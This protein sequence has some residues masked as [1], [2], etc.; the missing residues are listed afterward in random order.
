[1]VEQSQQ[2]SVFMPSCRSAGL[3]PYASASATYVP[4]G[5]FPSVDAAVS[6]MNATGAALG[7]PAST[8]SLEVTTVTSD[9]GSALVLWEGVS[10]V[11]D[12]GPVNVLTMP[13]DTAC[14]L[15]SC[16][17]NGVVN[18]ALLSDPPLPQS[19]GL[20]GETLG[21]VDAQHALLVGAGVGSGPTSFVIDLGTGCIQA[22]SPPLLRARNDASVTSFGA[23]AL[24][25][26]GWFGGN[27]QATAETAEVFQ[28]DPNGGAGG[29]TGVPVLLQSARQMH[30]AVELAT[31]ETVLIGGIPPG[32]TTA[33]TALESIS[34]ADIAMNKSSSRP[35]GT[36]LTV[37]RLEPTVFG[38]PTGSIFVGGGFDTTGLALNSVEWLPG[39]LSSLQQDDPDELDMLCTSPSVSMKDVPPWSFAPLEGGAVLAVYPGAAPKGCAS[40]VLIV[41]SGSA[42]Q[43][44][45]SLRPP[46]SPPMLLFAGAQSEPLLVTVDGVTRWQP[47]FDS[48]ETPS[49]PIALPLSLPSLTYLSADP[50]LALW[51]AGDSQIHALRFDT[52]NAYSTDLPNQAPL[53]TD[54]T[55]EFAP[56][57]LAGGPDV[58]FEEGNGLTLMNGASV[59]YTDATFADVFVTFTA[60]SSQLTPVFRDNDTGVMFPVPL[61]TCIGSS[62][63]LSQPV[64]V[65]RSGASI[66]AG[67]VTVQGLAPQPCP[68]H[69]PVLGERVAIGFM[70]PAMG[71]V[72]LSGVTVTRLGSAN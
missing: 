44:A 21:W 35:L 28:S 1:M 46:P 25:A 66:S 38:V 16:A 4:S 61:A 48:F 58:V 54:D 51:L 52:R 50:G 17:G 6:P 39:Q 69:A 56:D 8:R 20:T 72:T 34:P 64:Q 31:G 70:A 12:A 27:S 2:V 68:G 15:S 67:F 47:W 62:F 11:P 22:A 63:A 40:N 14:T 36:T 19:Q 10:L 55:N 7:I 60:S 65:Q 41:R 5:D 13:S 43:V 18:S 71:A 9:G 57:R 53:L 29:F 30:G 42:P 49:G 32:S 24:V 37:G 26:G 3:P 33:L 23:G 59:F 45:E